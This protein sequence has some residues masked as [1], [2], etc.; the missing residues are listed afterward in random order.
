[1]TVTK[2]AASGGVDLEATD[3]KMFVAHQESDASTVEVD[4]HDIDVDVETGDGI[5]DSNSVEDNKQSVPLG[6]RETKQT[7]KS[8]NIHLFPKVFLAGLA[9]P[10]VVFILCVATGIISSLL[11][12]FVAGN[13][14]LETALGMFYGGA[15]YS[16]LTALI[17]VPA[18]L[19]LG[20]PLSYFAWKL[21]ALN[22]KVI[23]LAASVIGG[24][25]FVV[26]ACIFLARVERSLWFVCLAIG[27]SGGFVNGYAFLRLIRHKA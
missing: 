6:S 16:V 7:S 11:K 14:D 27:A 17:S 3:K 25:F 24:I 15:V 21:E 5:L 4:K 26:L 23:L 20:L 22:T 9:S 10:L 1:M 2:I 18:T 13:L 8:T 19:F 12:F